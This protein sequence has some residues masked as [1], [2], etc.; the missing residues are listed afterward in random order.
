MRNKVSKNN[1]IYFSIYLSN[2]QYIYKKKIFNLYFRKPLKPSYRAENVGFRC[3]EGVLSQTVNTKGKS[4]SKRKN[5][6]REHRRIL[7]GKIPPRRAPR[8]HRIEETW[9]YKAKMMVS[10][11]LFDKGNKKD[12]PGKHYEL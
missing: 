3:A 5:L 4:S 1:Y 9:E 10:N 2:I 12:S 6:G 11:L 8:L 7:D